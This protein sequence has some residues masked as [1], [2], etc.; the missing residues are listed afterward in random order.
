[1]VCHRKLLIATIASG[2]LSFGVA[3]NAGVIY[4]N[5]PHVTTSG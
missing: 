3:A 4:N 1:M 2:M 5:L